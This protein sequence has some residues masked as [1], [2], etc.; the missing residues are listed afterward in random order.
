[1]FSGRVTQ[2]CSAFGEHVIE[3]EVQLALSKSLAK[4]GGIVSEFSVCPRISTDAG[5]SFHE[6]FIEFIVEPSNKEDFARH[7]NTCVE[8]QNIYYKDLIGSGVIGRLKISSVK[9]GGFNAYM[10]S[11]GKFGGQ[12]KCPHLSNKRD[13]GNFLLKNYV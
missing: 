10:K 5:D 12:N 9:T 11:I 6:W 7:L 4:F 8:A 1:L 2:Y 13:I 3:K